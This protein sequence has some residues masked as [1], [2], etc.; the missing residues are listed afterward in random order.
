[1]ANNCYYSMCITG[2]AEAIGKFVN[3]VKAG[4]VGGIYSCYIVASD[5]G[6]ASLQQVD[7]EKIYQ[8]TVDGDCKWSVAS[9]MMDR[10]AL[11]LLSFSKTLNLTIEIYFS[12]P[13]CGFQEY[14]MVTNGELV[15]SETVAYAEHPLFEYSSLEQLNRELGSHFTEDDVDGEYVKEGGFG[16]DFCNFSAIDDLVS[17]GYVKD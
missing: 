2:K 16:D 12:E 4:N 11:N 10:P 8:V 13:G 3:S 1:M 14:F 17:M 5:F 6:L 7:K 15:A 9:A